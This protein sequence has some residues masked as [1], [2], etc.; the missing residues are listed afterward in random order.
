MIICKICRFSSKANFN[1]QAVQNSGFLL[2]V[3][4]LLHT[5]LYPI[6][7]FFNEYRNITLTERSLMP[8]LANFH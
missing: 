2:L 3:T 6:K 5:K 8:G 7:K 1:K 4:P